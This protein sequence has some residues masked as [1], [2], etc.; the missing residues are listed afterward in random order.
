MINYAVFIITHGRP[1]N[2]KTLETLMRLK[3]TGS[4]YLVL[5]NLDETIDAYI[6]NYGKEHIII[7]DKPKY[8]Y[9][10]DCGLH[11]PFPKFAVFA[12]N[13][14]EDIAVELGLD[15]FMVFDDDITNF[16]ARFIEDGSLKSIPL[17]NC[18]DDAFMACINFMQST[19]IHCTG[20]GFCNVYRSGIRG[21]FNETPRIRL[22][23]GAFIRDTKVKVNWRLNM[24]EDLIT[25]LDHNRVGDVWLQLLPVQIDVLISEGVVEGGNSDA[26]NKFDNFTMNF[27]PT[28]VYPDC[29]FVKYRKNKW[30]TAL[31]ACKSMPKIISHK[32][33]H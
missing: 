6:N 27:L 13:A 3:F 5:D 10:T 1:D 18:I 20:F 23:A 9:S 17:Y 30:I 32:Y 7:F 22:C 14:V 24:V 4:W 31:D 33:R 12:R 26:Y 29:N 8:L 25:S 2:Q 16:R 19:N 11:K 28:I 15:Y 21:L